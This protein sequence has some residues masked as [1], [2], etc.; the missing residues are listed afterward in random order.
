M[1]KA[2]IAA[3][4][5]LCMAAVFVLTFQAMDYGEKDAKEGTDKVMLTVL[6]GQSTSDAGVEDM[7]DEMIAEKFPAV[8][9]EWECVDWGEKFDSQMQG[10]LAAGDVPDIIVGKAQD[11]YAYARSGNL[12]EVRAEGME[13]IEERIRDVVTID[14]KVYGIPYNAW[15]QGVV[16]NKDIF[17]K[18]QLQVPDTLEEMER[19]VNILEEKGVVPFAAHFQEGWKIGNMTMQF[20]LNNVFRGESN[21]G[22]RFREGKISFSGDPR[23]RECIEQNKYILNHTWDDALVIEQYES[24]RR[25]AEGEAA[26]YLTGSWSLQAMGQ[27]DTSTQYGFFP[28]P[29]ET[30]DASL[31]KETNMTFMMSNTSGH[32]DIINDIFT[33]LLQNEKL[34]QEILGFTSTYPVVDDMTITYQSAVEEDIKK[35]EDENRIIDAAIGNNQLIWKF[36]NDL[37]EEIFKWLNEENSMEQVLEYADEHR[38]ES[39][40]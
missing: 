29:N 31:I 37:A 17:D 32:Q 8:A 5:I 35:Y 7:I 10:R 12:A 22:S 27:Y 2:G 15:Y 21:W 4:L 20:M 14:G 3:I 16:Y 23:M 28:F 9:L 33:E 6:A 24:D 34:M 39:G 38:E 36:Q 26:M 1:K 19:T 18:L 25:F 30:G 40:N 11:V 13:R